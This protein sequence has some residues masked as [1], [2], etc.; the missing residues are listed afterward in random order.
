VVRNLGLVE[1]SSGYNSANRTALGIIRSSSKAS[2][3]ADS[4]WSSSPYNERAISSVCLLQHLVLRPGSPVCVCQSVSMCH[5]T[6]ASILEFS[7]IRSDC[8]LAGNMGR[9][10]SI[11]LVLCVA[12]V[13]CQGFIWLHPSVCPSVRQFAQCYYLYAAELALTKVV[14]TVMVRSWQ[15]LVVG[16]LCLRLCIC[17]RFASRWWLSSGSSRV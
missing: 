2:I 15:C 4:G 3:E 12:L 7:S 8:C 9:K 14:A 10:E 6:L 1:R 5:L 16:R 11:R 17:I 13:L